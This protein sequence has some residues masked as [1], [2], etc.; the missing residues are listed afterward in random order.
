MTFAVCPYKEGAV[1]RCI[2]SSR[3]FVLRIEN[4]QVRRD[5]LEQSDELATQLQAVDEN[6]TR[7]Y[8]RT[9]RIPSPTN[10]VILFPK[11]NPF[12]DSLCSSQGRHMFIGLAFNERND[13]FDFNTSLEDSKR[14]RLQELNPPPTFTGPSVDYSLKE[15]QK[16]RVAVPKIEGKKEGAGMSAAAKRRADRGKGGSKP[17]RAGGL[18]APS[19]RDTPG[20]RPDGS[21]AGELAG[22]RLDDGLSVPQPQED[23]LLA[24]MTA[25]PVAAPAPAPEPVLDP[26]AAASAQAPAQAQVVDP[27][28][29]ALPGAAPTPA[30]APAMVNPMAAF[31]AAAVPALAPV[32]QQAVIDPFAQPLVSAF[33]ASAAL[34]VHGMGGGDPFAGSN[35]D[36][37]NMGGMSNSIEGMGNQGQGQQR[38]GG[39]LP[40]PVMGG[41]GADPFANA[42][43]VGYIKS[44]M[45]PNNLSR[46]AIAKL[47]EERRRSFP[48]RVEA[49]ARTVFE[50]REIRQRMMQHLREA[51]Q[52]YI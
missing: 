34:P 8:L 40:P 25:P 4:A 15:G 6:H 43:G 39:L 23:S 47:L 11:P 21:S 14:E 32:Q 27:F 24:A 48:Q 16:I 12:R 35:A 19:T 5:Y 52:H 31:G 38:K 13:A 18:L 28:T 36:S 50:Q 17:L 3:Y 51:E 33:P 2:D 9:R 41:M 1:D 42:G 10:A 49:H 7:L 37:F 26:F 30:P 29:V 44:K 20:R 45:P 46:A 22:G